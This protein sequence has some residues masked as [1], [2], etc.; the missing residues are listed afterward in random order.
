MSEDVLGDEHANPLCRSDLDSHADTCCAGSNMVVL[1][2]SD[3]KVNV[4]PFADSYDAIPDIPIATVATA[5]DYPNGETIILV[6]HE[7]LYFGSKLNTSLLN[8]NQMRAHGITVDDTPRQFDLSSAHQVV[9]PGLEAPLPLELHGIISYLPTRLPT[10]KELDECARYDMTSQRP[11]EPYS[12]AFASKEACAS[13]PSDYQEPTSRHIASTLYCDD[14]GERLISSVRIFADNTDVDALINGFPQRS[15]DGDLLYPQQNGEASSSAMHMN[16]NE[17]LVFATTAHRTHMVTPMELSKRW[18]IGLD[19]AKDTISVTTQRGVRQMLHPFHRRV[20]TRQAHLQYPLLKSRFYSDTMFSKVAGLGGV[21]C[22]QVFT[23]EHDCT[24]FYPMKSKKDAGIMLSHFVRDAGIPTQLLTDQALEQTGGTWKDTINHYHIDARLSEAYSP[25]Q[26]RAESA[27]KDL[28]RGIRHASQRT[29]SPQRLWNYC[30]EWVAAIGKLTARPLPSLV[31]RTPIEVLTGDTPD[32][33]EYLHHDW[34]QYVWYHDPPSAFPEQQRRLGRWLGV[35]HTIGSALFY[36]ILTDKCKVVSRST[37]QNVLQEESDTDLVKQQMAALDLAINSKIGDKVKDVDSSVNIDVHVP[38]EI[39]EDDFQVDAPDE[40]G[41]DRPEADDFENADCLDKYISTKV[42]LPQG[43]EMLRAKVIGRKRGPNGEPI[44]HAHS[45][46][47][48]DTREYEVEFPD[49][50]TDTYTANLIAENIYSQVDDEGHENLVIRDI[51]DHRKD[52][53]A[54]SKDDMYFTDYRGKQQRRLSTKGWHLL[55]Q[56]RDGT[57]TWEPLRNLKES[58]PV[59]VAE[60]AVANKIAEEPAFAWWV[61]HV[62]R[63]RDRIIAKVKSRY[64]ESTHKYGVALPKSVE[65]ALR[66]DTESGTNHWRKAIE[67]EMKNVLPAFEFRDDDCMP[68]GHKKISCHMIFTVKMD[69]TRKA[70][71]V[72]DGHRTDPPKDM[73]FSS[74]VSRDSVRIAFLLAALNDLDV[75]AADVQNAYLNAGTNEKLYI[76]AGKEFGNNAGRPALIVRALYGL[77]S[78][79]ERWRSHMAQSLRDLGFTSSLADPDMWMRAACKPNGYEYYEYVL[80]Y[81]DDIL[82]VSHNPM[83]VMQGIKSKYKMKDDSVA[84]PETYLGAQVKKW[85][86]LDGDNPG[87]VRWSMSSEKYVKA[88]IRDVELECSKVDK[89]LPTR[90]STPMTPGYRPECDQSPELDARRANYYQGL[91]GVLRW[92]CELGRVDILINVSMLSHFLAS[93]RQG[94]LDQVFHI[95]G[96]LKQHSRSTMVFDDTEPIVNEARFKKCDWVEFYPDAKE[97][98]PRNAPKPR[99][100]TVTIDCYVDAD[101]AGCRMTRRSHTGVLIFCNRAPILWHSKRQ[102]TV[103]TSTFGSEFIAMRT[104]VEMI[105]G[106]RYKLR[107]FGVPIDSPA[108]VYCDNEAVVRNTTS[109]ESTLK[110]KHNAI[111]YH[112]VREA[113]AARTLRIAKEDT[114]TNLADM[115]TKPLPTVKL[116]QH[117]E[118]VLW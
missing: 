76:I 96:Y 36:Y 60:Y 21:T 112:R 38:N 107:M 86:I 84:P 11:W 52:G 5:Y 73:T 65:D 114:L 77:K 18:N 75:L 108:N 61:K 57:E 10:H 9:I 3:T 2:L 54:I 68:L 79:G 27:I 87:K 101:H 67:K 70:R 26:N 105:E 46:P 20:R 113:V 109:P 88:A 14:L 42:L 41:Y 13:D 111:S 22:A 48:L 1:E 47:I 64:W 58:V 71:L 72:A 102:N 24:Y 7:T 53:H 23:N 104:A 78:S 82:A 74:V 110:K 28:K 34:Y 37:V 118:A 49:G 98:I 31:G 89:I 94:H 17:R 51:I 50:S 63:K 16:N 55:V 44:G 93:P 39:F 19:I 45:N 32:I 56:W 85:Y 66:L 62:L 100:K 99:G 43:G 69:L 15:L 30:G 12:S 116:K 92:I 95:Y 117:S 106:L 81:V 33:S 25:W 90:C 103:E 35:A 80:V 97:A 6:F 115:L 91:I 4:R 59:Q 29:G 8:P 83:R 40:E